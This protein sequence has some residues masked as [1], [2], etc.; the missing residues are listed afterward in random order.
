M[1][2][3]NNVTVTNAAA[4]FAAVFVNPGT[5]A[6]LEFLRFAMSQS[7]TATSAMYACAVQT[8]AS[9][10]PTLTSTTPSKLKFGD[11]ASA[12]TGN[13]TGAAGTAGT[14]AS[15]AG[16]GSKTVVFSDN[17]NNLNG[18]LWVPTP[19]ETLI[20]SASASSGLGLYWMSTPGSLTQWSGYCVFA[21][22]S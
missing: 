9:A 14:N 15:V 6:S 13:T 2:S 21:E 8:Q 17:F 5:T 20:M 19:R 11:P 7:G 10:F 18:Y 3:M 1:V 4:N 12:I 22:L 16:A